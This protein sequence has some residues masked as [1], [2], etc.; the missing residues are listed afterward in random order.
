MTAPLIS[1]A[2]GV[3]PP[4]AATARA[5]R[6]AATSVAK[7]A[8]DLGTALRHFPNDPP[9]S[10]PAQHRAPESFDAVLARELA[11]HGFSVRDYLT[12]RGVTA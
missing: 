7:H 11:A 10:R 5:R 3:L 9:R 12:S 4:D 6:R 2:G 1:R 8:A